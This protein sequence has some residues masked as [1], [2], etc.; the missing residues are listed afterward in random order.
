MGPDLRSGMRRPWLPSPGHTYLPG[1]GQAADS[2]VAEAKHDSEEGIKVLLFLEAVSR[3]PR[4]P[5]GKQP[6]PERPTSRQ[7]P[8]LGPLQAVEL[9]GWDGEAEAPEDSGKQGVSRFGNIQGVKKKWPQDS[10]TH[11]MSPHRHSLSCQ[12]NELPEQLGPQTGPGAEA[13][14]RGHPVL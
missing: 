8:G 2:R 9:H 4:D 12:L 5:Q 14:L 6:H 13:Q 11:P 1:V 10:V 7:E 3:R